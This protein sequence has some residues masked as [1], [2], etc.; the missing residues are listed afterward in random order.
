MKSDI[1]STY[2]ELKDL[3]RVSVVWIMYPYPAPG[4][5]CH[6]HPERRHVS[7]QPFALD[8]DGYQEV[9]RSTSEGYCCS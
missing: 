4:D 7:A 2:V 1:D 8:C 6:T 3:Q 5:A 9:V